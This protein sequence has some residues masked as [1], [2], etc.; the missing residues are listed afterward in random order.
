VEDDKTYQKGFNDG[1]MLQQ[2]EPEISNSL[3]NIKSDNPYLEALIEGRDQYIR[4]MRERFKEHTKT[5]PNHSKVKGVD[6]ER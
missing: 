4:E 5:V 2:H 3:N 1:Y 6:R